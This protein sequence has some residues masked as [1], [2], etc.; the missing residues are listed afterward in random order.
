MTNFNPIYFPGLNWGPFDPNP[1]AVSV[2]GHPIQWYGIIIAVGFLLAAIYGVR[3]APKVGIK[4][5]DIADALFFCVPIALVGARLYY[6]V[7]NWKMFAPNP[8]AML[9]IWQGGVAIYGGIIFALITA[10]IVAKHKKIN[11]FALLD[12]SVIGLC[13]GQCIGRWGNFINREV[14][15]TI[16]DLPWRMEIFSWEAGE[17][18]SVHPTF[19]Y[20]SLWTLAGFIL[21]HNLLAR[22][23]Y[24]GQIALCY[25]LWYGFGRGMIEFIRVDNLMF[26]GT[27]IQV[28]QLVGF[29]T[30][31][32]AALLLLWFRFKPVRKPLFVD[33]VVGEVG[34]ASEE[35][36]ETDGKSA[37]AIEIDLKYRIK[38]KD[39]E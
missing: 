9:Y 32:I 21:L 26:F 8:I 6:V 4:G 10:V 30:A 39:E 14:Y 18:I 35:V 17:R 36:G 7:F 5:D 22:R 12:I 1:T 19:F 28:S 29:G 24:D 25:A 16:T 11:P 13:I 23:K 34:E 15:G 3:R 33:R 31:A 2:F 20:E 37:A 38:D 27:G